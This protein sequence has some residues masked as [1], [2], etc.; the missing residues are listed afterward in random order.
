MISMKLDTQA[1]ENLL[2]NDDGTIK[3]ELQQS[4]IEEFSRRHIKALINDSFFDTKMQMLKKE[5]GESI[6]NLFG[7]WVTKNSK[8][9]FELNP[10]IR[11][12][13]KLQSKT[14]VTHELDNVEK[15]VKEIYEKTAKKI[16][17]EYESKVE[18][19][20]SRLN[21]YCEHLE[22]ETEKIR[23]RLLSD[24]LDEIL[25]EHIRS[26][27]SESFSPKTNKEIA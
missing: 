5:A 20:E 10:Q 13:I 7:N 3:L 25:K 14:A 18:Y 1:L 17:T 12:M 16:K 27:L 21:Q 4:V 24:K 22:K 8:K 9:T 19:L 15:H 23:E 26:I 11:D 2:K 6:E